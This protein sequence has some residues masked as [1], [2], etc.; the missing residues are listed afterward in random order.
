MVRIRWSG[1]EELREQLRNLTPE[2][3]QEAGLIVDGA[4]EEARRNV[5]AGYMAAYR[6]GAKGGTGNLRSGLRITHFEKGRFHAG[7]ILKNTAPH[8]WLY[9]NGSQLRHFGSASR[10]TMPAAHTFVREVIRARR[11]MYIAFGQMLE[12]HG[13]TVTNIAA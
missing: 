12:R 9:D 10:G 8:A 6:P 2:L 7:A 5:Y 11:G 1:L 3:A 13:M 4:V